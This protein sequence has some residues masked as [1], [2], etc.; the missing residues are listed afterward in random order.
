MTWPFLL[1]RLSC[2]YTSQV[3]LTLPDPVESATAAAA[4]NNTSY[5]QTLEFAPTA[6]A[7]A[8][9]RGA[10]FCGVSVSRERVGGGGGIG[11]GAG[12]GG[13][14]RGAGRAGKV[15]VVSFAPTISL[16][17]LLATPADVRLSCPSSLS[18]S[19]QQRSR[20]R[21]NDAAASQVGIAISGSNDVGD[22]KVADGAWSAT[23]ERGSA[24]SWFNCPPDEE[25]KSV[26]L[27][28]RLFFFFF[29]LFYFLAI[30]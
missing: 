13:G 3:I 25:V 18:L 26:R 21:T 15:T 6:P 5:H 27:F 7:H 10:I 17:N 23:I 29:C 30:L 1:L 19:L 9:R 20:G 4:D 8:P 2:G 11:S 22:D 24:V 16:T 28:V 12:A 14:G